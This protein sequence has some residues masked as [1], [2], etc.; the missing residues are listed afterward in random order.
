[1]RRRSGSSIVHGGAAEDAAAMH[2]S[3]LG[4][5]ILHRNWRR[6]DCEIDIVAKRADSLCFCEVK[7]RRDTNQGDGFTYI[8]DQKLRQMHYAAARF[9]QENPTQNSVTPQLLVASVV[10]WDFH[11]TLAEVEWAG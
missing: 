1:M 6:P 11:V 8:T 7:F 5:Q 4:W 9:I 3:Q 10:G 2:L